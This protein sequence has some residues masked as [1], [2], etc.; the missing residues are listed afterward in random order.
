MGGRYRKNLGDWGENIAVNFLR[1]RGF[2]IFER[3]FQTTQGEIDIV[4]KYGDDFYFVEVKT[5]LQKDLANDLA[6]GR[7]KKQRFEKAVKSYCYR[8]DIKNVGIILAGIIILADKIN[9]TANIRFVT[10]V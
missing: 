3:N 10:M 7:I 6:I 9:K 8:R 4:A 5:R 2:S 1:R